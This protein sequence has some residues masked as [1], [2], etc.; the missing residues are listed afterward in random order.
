MYLLGS[1]QVL[2]DDKIFIVRGH[3]VGSAAVA[4]PLTRRLARSVG[5]DKRVSALNS[6]KKKIAV[7]RE[8][9]EWERGK[10]TL[11]GETL[12][13][14]LGECVTW[15]TNSRSPMKCACPPCNRPGRGRC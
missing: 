3:R 13:R 8:S 11:V 1:Q 7:H 2:E 5:C 6:L 10:C 14:S 4:P 15:A 9:G 12:S